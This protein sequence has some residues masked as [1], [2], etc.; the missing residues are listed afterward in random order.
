MDIAEKSVLTGLLAA[1]AVNNLFVFDN[2]GSYVPFFA[3]LA[4]V[5]MSRDGRVI[6]WLG[7]NPVG[8]EAVNYAVIPITFIVLIFTLYFF[9][10][11]QIIVG[12]EITDAVSTCGNGNVNIEAFQSAINSNVYM[13]EQEVREQLYPCLAGAYWDADFSMDRKQEFTNLAL[14]EM[15]KQIVSTPLDSR[16]Y[17]LAGQSLNQIG[18]VGTAETYLSKAYELSPAR[19]IFDFEFAADLIYMKNYAQALS[20]LKSAYD[21]APQY[22]QA[23]EAYAIA[24]QLNGDDVQAR[25]ILPNNPIFNSTLNTV[26]TYVANNEFNKLFILFNGVTFVS[27][28]VN[29]VISQAQM[30]YTQGMV[31]QAIQLLLTLE[32][33][34]PELK[35]GLDGMI[36]EMSIK[37]A[38]PK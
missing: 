34:H 24:L 15:E 19:Q 30:E 35:T 31:Q 9:N 11:R 27:D 4:Y 13:A 12:S 33:I 21:S 10:V 16:S 36:K 6:K 1:Y 3:M 8:A 29:L 28:D 25:S 5:N 14:G 23:A 37:L 38:V 32:N 2:L 7:T 22:V 18:Q 26:K 20:I 17:Y